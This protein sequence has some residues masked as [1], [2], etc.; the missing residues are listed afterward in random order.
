[1]NG[2]EL[3]NSSI[4]NLGIG[5]CYLGKDFKTNNNGVNK[6]DMGFYWGK[7]RR[8]KR[9]SGDNRLK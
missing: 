4:N 3:D 6:R 2:L 5:S 7:E 1:M 8:S 9:K